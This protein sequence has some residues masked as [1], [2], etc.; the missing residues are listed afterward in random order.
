MS[1]DKSR[2]S[3]SALMQPVWYNEHYLVC[4]INKYTINVYLFR[5]TSINTRA[6]RR[7]DAHDNLSNIQTREIR[8][9]GTCIFNRL[10]INSPAFND[11]F[12]IHTYMF[13]L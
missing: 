12:L 6:R 7:R 5:T 2:A 10:L 3:D 11:T 1:N 9:T 13:I 8:I 4:C